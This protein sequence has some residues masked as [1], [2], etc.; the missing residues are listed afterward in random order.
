MAGLGRG[1]GAASPSR[2][3]RSQLWGGRRGSETRGTSSRPLTGSG[4]KEMPSRPR[5]A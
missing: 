4:A 5:P 1:T 3:D 2:L